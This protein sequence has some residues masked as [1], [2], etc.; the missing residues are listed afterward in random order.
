M[1]VNFDGKAHMCDTGFRMQRE[2]KFEM[3]LPTRLA[4]VV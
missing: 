3:K 4:S 2:G 1:N